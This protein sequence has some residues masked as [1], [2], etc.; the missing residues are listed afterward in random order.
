[1]QKIVNNIGSLFIYTITLSENTHLLLNGKY[2]CM[3]DLLFDC[4]GFSC[5]ASVELARDL[6]VWSNQNQSN[7]YTSNY[8]VSECSLTLGQNIF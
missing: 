8:E 3:A 2:H 7:S 1:M 5:F 4:L 6:Q